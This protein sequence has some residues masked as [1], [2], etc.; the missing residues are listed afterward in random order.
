MNIL[1]ISGANNS[2]Q[3]NPENT[4]IAPRAELPERQA[5]PVGQRDEYIH[6]MQFNQEDANT[7]PREEIPARQEQ[8][9][10][11]QDEYIQ[12]MNFIRSAVYNVYDV[13]RNGY[14]HAVSNTQ[15]Q[16]NNQGSSNVLNK[17]LDVILPMGRKRLSVF[18]EE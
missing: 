2:L 17:V 15:E 7:A 14:V 4:N 6:Q 16:R 1:D 13:K 9:M 12:S 5:Q 10:E 11:P 3:I 8:P 18:L